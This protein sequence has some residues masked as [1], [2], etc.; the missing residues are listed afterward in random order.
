M[1]RIHHPARRRDR[2]G[3]LTAR[4]D[5]TEQSDAP[6][7]C[8]SARSG[9]SCSTTTP[10][11]T[12]PPT[13]K[14]PG[15]RASR[16]GWRSRPTAP[17]RVDY[18][19]NPLCGGD[20]L[21]DADGF[22]QIDN[23]GPATYFIDVHPP[24]GPCNSNP[25]SRWY[26]T[27]TID[28]G[29]QLL[30]AGRGGQRRHR[31]AG[32]AALGAAE[33]P[34][35][36]LVRIRLRAPAVRDRRAPARS[37]ARA[38]NWVEWPPYTTGTLRRA[39]RAT[40]SSRC[41]TPPP[42]RRL[43]RPGRRAGQ[44][45]HPE[46]AGRATTTCRSGT[47]SSAT[48]CGSSRSRS[49]AARSSTSTT[50]VTTARSASAFRAGSAGSTA[51]STRT[52]SNGQYDAGVDTADRQ[53]R[54]GPAVAR[55]LD[56]GVH[57]HRRVRA[58]TSTRPPR[59]ARSGAGSS[60]SRA[61]R[62]SRPT[63]GRRSTTS[64]PVPSSRPVPS[65]RHAVGQPMHPD[66]PGRRAADQPAAAGRPPSHG[67]LGQAR[68]PGRHARPDRRHHLLRHD[69]QRVRR[70]TQ[71]HE[72]Y[73]P[74]IPDVTVYLES[75]GPD[76]VPNTGDDVVVNKY[77]TDHWQQPNASQDP[78]D[79]NSVHPEL[80]PDPRLQRQRRQRS[81]QPGRSGRT[82]SRCRSPASRPRTARSTAATPSPTT[83]RAATT[84]TADDGTCT[85]ARDPVPL[86]AG[87]YIT[88][89][90]MPKDAERLARAATR[91][92]V[93]RTSREHPTGGS[94]RRLGLPLP[95][96]E[97]GG[98]QRRPRQPLHPAAFPTPPCAGDDHVIDQ[99]TLTPR[100]TYYSV[101][102]RARAAVRQ[103]ARRAAPT[104]RTPTPT[105]T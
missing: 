36:L 100:S 50:P 104:A 56:Q 23:L 84:S 17:S 8:R 105:S 47:S 77:V 30:A 22:V 72:D 43:H 18:N 39:G 41:A 14:R 60:T 65:T 38:R 75:P 62:A 5:L 45:R 61:S 59:A 13:P 66:R 79:G 49:S 81:V 3:T 91:S 53:H 58:T 6:P 80:Q 83:A 93:T 68:L 103:E 73:E 12:A 46:R 102:E 51:R 21:T 20:C 94:R 71:A 15:C 28:G 69:P 40:R 27:T 87:T 101:S 74:A 35:R 48:S 95:A 92:A 25:N 96:R 63:P 29:L 76:G 44:L 70:A 78:P 42:T 67:R 4:I 2:D 64:T 85:A 26:Q 33:Q 98:R 19:N 82:A 31:R 55:R 97:G 34:H 88:H 89:A 99:S 37:R 57:G 9:S 11:P 1:G 24:D 52:N 32:R 90:V 7:A 86:V 16:S 10:G 54:H